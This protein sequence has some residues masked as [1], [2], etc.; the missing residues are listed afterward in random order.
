MRSIDKSN[1]KKVEHDVVFASCHHLNATA[2]CATINRHTPPPAWTPFSRKFP[3]LFSRENSRQF[4]SKEKND[5]FINPPL[6]ARASRHILML[7][8]LLVLLLCSY[9]CCHCCCYCGFAIAAAIATSLAAAAATT[10]A[11]ASVCSTKLPQITT[12]DAQKQKCD[13]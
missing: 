7:L 1:T 4:L 10:A 11:V 6:E 12:D 3:T 5:V 9:C 13:L 8:L 2:Y